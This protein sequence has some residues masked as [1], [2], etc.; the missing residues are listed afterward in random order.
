M[1]VA[2]LFVPLHE[3]GAQPRDRDEEESNPRYL[4]GVV[5]DILGVKPRIDGETV[6][7][8][9]F[10]SS[11]GQGVPPYGHG[12]AFGLS[13]VSEQLLSHGLFSLH[14]RTALGAGFGSNRIHGVSEQTLDVGA[15][16]PIG[17]LPLGVFARVGTDASA[18]GDSRL[19]TSRVALPYGRIGLSWLG[20][21]STI[22][23]AASGGYVVGGRF[24]VGDDGVRVLT[25]A[26]EFGP[27]MMLNTRHV[28]LSGELRRIDGVETGVAPMWLGRAMACGLLRSYSIGLCMHFSY[29]AGEVFQREER[30]RTE[31][32]SFFGGWTVGYLVE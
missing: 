27:A 31:A 17:D 15:R 21:S 10:G 4:E 30:I 20:R 13:G 1:G 2:L 6:I 7:G 22:E 9:Y 11:Q 23:L 14:T 3:V 24:N 19:Y 28:L 32:T 12:I 8:L 29:G 25:G 18:Y 5:E 16:L 26:A